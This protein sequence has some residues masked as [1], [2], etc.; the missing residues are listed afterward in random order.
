MKLREA[1]VSIVAV[2]M[3]ALGARRS[4]VTWWGKTGTFLLMFS[5]PLFLAGN[6]D[7][8]L[9]DAALVAAWLC[10][11]PGVVISYYSAASYLPAARDA[12]RAGRAGR[13]P[14]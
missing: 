12:L 7:W 6:A 4:D 5:F 14:A 10:G 9:A 2:G 11:I 3:G 13:R 8:V 1:A